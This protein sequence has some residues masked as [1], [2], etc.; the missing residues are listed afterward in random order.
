MIT[1]NDVYQAFAAYGFET[2]GSVCLGSF[3]GYALS[4]QPNGSSGYYLDAAT[5]TPANDSTFRKSYKTIKPKTVTGIGATKTSTRLIV[6]FRGKTPLGQQVDELLRS[7]T[8]ALRETGIAPAATC[9]VCGGAAPESLGFFRG[10][11]QPVHGGCLQGLVTK[12]RETAEDNRVNGSYLTGFLGALLGAVVG[13]LPSL[14][15]IALTDRI[16]AVLFAL[17]PLASMWCYRKFGGKMDKASIGIVVVLS[18]LAVLLMTA[19]SASMS[20]ADEYGEPF[21]EVFPAILAYVVTAEGFLA[22]L[23]D[24]IVPLIFLA[25]G[26]VLAW[27][28]LRQTGAATVQD[29]EA[30]AAT[31]RPNPAYMAAQNA[32][33]YQNSTGD[34]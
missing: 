14:L 17:I 27:R 19:V 28:F 29:A 26:L 23:Q 21:F 25:I 6:V 7:F 30:A 24:S 16:Y 32:P 22:L 1:R 12:A 8:G 20:L 34:N 2:A 3:G 18:L 11:Y 13:I 31:L 33:V 5:R 9:A 15:L 10:T 4:L